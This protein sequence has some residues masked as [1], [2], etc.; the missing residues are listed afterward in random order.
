MAVSGDELWVGR[1]LGWSCS[2][3]LLLLMAVGWLS[4]GD[5]FTPKLLWPQGS[6]DRGRWLL[7]WT[8]LAP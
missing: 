8:E 5:Q 3:C 4:F 6:G 1:N 2:L 7:A